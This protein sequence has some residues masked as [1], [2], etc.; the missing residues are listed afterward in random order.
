MV[1]YLEGHGR[2][3]VAAMADA[4]AD[5]PASGDPEVY[6]DPGAC[7]TTKLIEID[8][9]DP[10][11]RTSTAPSRPTC[12]TPISEMKEKFAAKNGWPTDME[13]GLIGSCTN[14]S[15]ED[16]SRAA[17]WRAMPPKKRPEGRS[18]IHHQPRLGAG[19]LH[20]RARRRSG[21]CLR[22]HRRPPSWPMP[23]ARA[24]ASGPA[25]G[26][27]R[28]ERR[29]PSSTPSTATSP[30]APTA[31]PTRTPSWPRPRW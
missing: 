22:D 3:E 9:S 7:I 29:T 17:S 20:G 10:G 6:A 27:D 21:R 1:R 16:M 25:P 28:A 2:A 4:I 18:R 30:S 31:T 13:V 19:A 11:A 24:S 15:Y 23:A 14:S 5:R 12:A 26:A 8:L